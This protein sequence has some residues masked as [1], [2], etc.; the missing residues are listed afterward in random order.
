MPLDPCKLLLVLVVMEKLQSDVLSTMFNLQSLPLANT[1]FSFL[2]FIA[3]G[4]YKIISAI[5]SQ[6]YHNIIGFPLHF[7]V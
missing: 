5:H 1:S 4:R 7:L 2:D 3:L 6:C